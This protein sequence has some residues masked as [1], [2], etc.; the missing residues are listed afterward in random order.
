[1]ISSV[2]SDVFSFETSECVSQPH[3]LAEEQR[4]FF[5]F[6][7]PCMDG[8]RLVR[9]SHVGTKGLEQGSL[10]EKLNVRGSSML[11]AAREISSES[12][13]MSMRNYS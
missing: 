1:M 11:L 6:S 8:R 7:F 12:F 13:G 10:G 4:T 5:A 3:E 9:F 2:L